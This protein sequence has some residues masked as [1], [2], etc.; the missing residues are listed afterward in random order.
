MMRD[1]QLTR[2]RLTG[3]QVRIGVMGSASGGLGGPVAEIC[4][5]LG[6]SIAERGCC[7][8]T[9]ACPGFPHEAVLGAKAAGG[10]VVGISPA[11]TLK[12]HVEAYGSPYRE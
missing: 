4:R 10:H 11:A 8:L 9:G 7:L 5:R 12:E 2:D 6:R 3:A 1:G